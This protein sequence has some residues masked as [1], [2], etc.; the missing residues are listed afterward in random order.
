MY[1][2]NICIKI[3]KYYQRYRLRSYPVCRFIPSCSEYAILAFKNLGF[4]RAVF[5]ITLRIIYCQPFGRKGFHIDTPQ[6]K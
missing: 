4:W 5:K 1:L 3:V 2:S 6:G